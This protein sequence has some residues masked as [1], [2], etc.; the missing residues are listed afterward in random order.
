MKVFRSIRWKLALL[1]SILF[2]ISISLISIFL[3]Y[4]I[5]NELYKEVD[6]FLADEI[7]E[8]STFVIEHHHNAVEIQE[9]IQNEASALRKHYRMYYALLDENKEVIFQSSFFEHL[10][11]QQT[12]IISP[13]VPSL[14]LVEI[15]IDDNDTPYKVRIAT[16]RVTI[17]NHVQY[18]VQVGMNLVRIHKT[19]NGYKK[20]IFLVT[21]ILLFLALFG[22][23]FLAS[24]YLKPIT[25]ISNTISRITSLDLK[26]RIELRETGDEL[27]QL[28]E[29][30]NEMFDRLEES[31]QRI[32]SF[33]FDVA[34]ELRTPLTILIGEVEVALTNKKSQKEYIAL[35]ESN[36]EELK[37]LIQLVNNLLFIAQSENVKNLSLEKVNLSL[38]LKDMIELYQPVIEEKFLFL[39]TKIK[40]NVIINGN[41]SSLEQLIT[42]LVQN[43]IQYNKKNGSINIELSQ[44]DRHAVLK[45]SDTG[46]GIEKD[47]YHKVFDRFYRTDLSRNRHKGGTGLGLSIVKAIVNSY[48]G[49]VSVSSIVNKGSIF[50]VRIPSA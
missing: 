8:F 13:A 39:N 44:S 45:V 36:F 37:R 3:Y 34:H 12:H 46:I 17:N 40:E 41:T 11:E 7:E 24:K 15:Q 43:A 21:P 30:I 5:K 29:K 42:N 6:Y 2:I 1:Y 25:N 20:N 47:Q 33:S 9:Q 16:K 28:S 19:I 32:S 26:E 23:I 18:Y 49:S 22:G 38:I 4:K 50:T 31:Y 10:P 14:N 48:G 35:L 27:D